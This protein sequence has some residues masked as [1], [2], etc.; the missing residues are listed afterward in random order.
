MNAL[1]S[2]SP[3]CVLFLRAIV[4]DDDSIGQ[5][6][7]L[8]F[9]LA[10]DQNVETSA[11]VHLNRDFC[12]DRVQYWGDGFGKFDRFNRLKIERF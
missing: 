6:N 12:A 2:S 4:D 8:V 7:A 11:K 5:F 3:L 9:Q 10:C 1:D